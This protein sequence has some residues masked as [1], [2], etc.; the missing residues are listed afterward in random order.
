MHNHSHGCGHS[1]DHDHD[2]HHQETKM[3]FE[4]QLKTLFKHW[5]S[6]NDSHATNYREW[7]KKAADKNMNDTAGLLEEIAAMTDRISE[8]I[9]EAEKTV[10]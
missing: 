9:R 5:C 6:H 8:K 10:K 2:H 1:H 4:D 7:A 3:S